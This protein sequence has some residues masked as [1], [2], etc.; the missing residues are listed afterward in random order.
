MN[1]N[2]GR[3]WTAEEKQMLYSSL[4]NEELAGKEYKI[5][6]IRALAK[7]LGVKLYED[8]CEQ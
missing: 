1:Y 2:F 5:L 6:R 8:L 3:K 4:S 7:K